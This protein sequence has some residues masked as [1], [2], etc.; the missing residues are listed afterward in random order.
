MPRPLLPAVAPLH[1]PAILPPGTAVE[2]SEI[3][4][5]QI[6]SLAAAKG[7][8]AALAEI[9][10]PRFRANL[11]QTPRRAPTWPYSFIWA[12]PERWLVTSIAPEDLEQTLRTEVADLAAVTDQTDSRS[13][14]RIS[15]PKARAT[16]AKLLPI[17]LHPRAFT[18]NQTA[19]TA[20]IHINLQIWQLDDTPTYELCV[21]RSY[22]DH[23]HHALHAAAAE[24][25]APAVQ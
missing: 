15:G 13:L 20:A 4:N 5:L 2:I 23:F 11:P 25:A 12:G 3:T 9:I 6:A 14:L 10:H 16:L 21:F 22:A 1:H 17:D 7:K 19:L 24:F 8:S 18:P